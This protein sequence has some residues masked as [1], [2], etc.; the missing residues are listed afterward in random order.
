MREN[1][2]RREICPQEETGGGGACDRKLDPGGLEVEFG[3][4]MSTITK[5]MF[6]SFS[7]TLLAL[8]PGPISFSWL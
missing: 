4:M 3:I 5:E 8:L 1:T 7:L 6:D 2:L